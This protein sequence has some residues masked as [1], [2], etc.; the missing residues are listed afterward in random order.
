MKS[1]DIFCPLKVLKNKNKTE[2][3]ATFAV[4]FRDI[5]TFKIFFYTFHHGN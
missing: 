2:A 5:A 1:C 3:A 4:Y